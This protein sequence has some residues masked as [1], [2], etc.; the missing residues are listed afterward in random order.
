MILRKLK[1]F[2]VLYLYY[3]LEILIQEVSITCYFNNIKKK[4]ENIFE[5]ILKLL[6]QYDIQAI[7]TI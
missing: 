1:N 3:V 7:N 5:S 2:Y 6:L 4:R